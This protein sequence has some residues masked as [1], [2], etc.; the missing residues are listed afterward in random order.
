M[1]SGVN[2]GLWIC[3]IFWHTSVKATLIIRKLIYKGYSFSFPAETTVVDGSDV[4]VNGSLD[5]L[6]DQPSDL[7]DIFNQIEIYSNLVIIPVG[8]I[9][10]I[11]CLITFV[12][13]KISHIPTGLTLTCLSIADNIVLVSSY[14]LQGKKLSQY[15]GIPK[16]LNKH[17][18]VR[19]GVGYLI[20]AGFLLSGVLLTSATIERYVSVRFPLKVKSWNLDVKTKI[21]LVVYFIAAF[22]LSSFAFLYYNIV[23]MT[24]DRCLYSPKY[25]QICYVN[26]IIFNSAFLETCCS[27]NNGE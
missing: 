25:D 23:P 2:Y 27:D 10:N 19:Q 14:F 24:I 3:A 7:L 1:Q 4:L 13:S 12:K 21:L 16:L 15:M 17:T 5:E 9:L 11:L 22:G 18:L 6:L 20:N 26:E 8:I